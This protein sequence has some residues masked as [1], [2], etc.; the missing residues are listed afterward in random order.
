MRD[1]LYLHGVDLNVTDR[2]RANQK[3]A[4]MCYIGKDSSF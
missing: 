1:E 4:K 2:H 3:E